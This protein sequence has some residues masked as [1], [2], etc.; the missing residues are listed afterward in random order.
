MLAPL[1]CCKRSFLTRLLASILYLVSIYLVSP[2]SQHL[3]YMPYSLCTG[4]SLCLKCSSCK[5]LHGLLLHILQV[6]IQSHLLVR[7]LLITFSRTLTPSLPS[8]IFPHLF[9]FLHSTHHSL[10]QYTVY[11][12]LVLIVHFGKNVNS[13]R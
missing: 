11:L 10:T 6:F 8:Q 12:V 1:D 3:G 4:Y 7:P 13:M 9:N 5:H 2:Y